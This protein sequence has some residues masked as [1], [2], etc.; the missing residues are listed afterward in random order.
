MSA[1]DYQNYI[2]KKIRFDTKDI[3]FDLYVKRRAPSAE[4]AVNR[5]PESFISGGDTY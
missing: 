1:L 4:T 2:T 3:P 5:T